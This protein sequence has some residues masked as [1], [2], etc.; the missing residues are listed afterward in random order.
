MTTEEKHELYKKNQSLI[1]KMFPYP[2]R[3][4]YESQG[5]FDHAYNDVC[6]E[7]WHYVEEI[8]RD[9]HKEPYQ[10]KENW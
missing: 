7:R 1:E 4:A 10:R 9:E 2:N 5:E 6:V 3:E 8:S